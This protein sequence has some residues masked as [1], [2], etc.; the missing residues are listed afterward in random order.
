MVGAFKLSFPSCISSYFL[1]RGIL[2]M[3]G[4]SCRVRTAHHFAKQSFA[5]KCVPKQSMGTRGKRIILQKTE[6]RNPKTFTMPPPRITIVM[7]SFNQ[8]EY[9]EEAM[10]S[11]LDQG[12]VNL[13]FM[14]L[15]G[16]SRDNSSA[17]IEKYA[18]RLA[19]WQSRP[20]G[21]QSDALAQG[22]A[23][24]TGDLWGWINSDDALLPG[25][26]DAIG[27]AAQVCPAA[28]L[29]GGNYMLMDQAGR[30]TRCK[31]HPANAGWFAGRGIFAFNPPG[32][33]FRPRY[34][35]AVGG[36]RRDLHFA[37][38][39]DLYFR[40]IAQ[41]AMYVHVDRYLSVFRQH[42]AQKPTVHR[43]AAAAEMARLCR[44]EWPQPLS[45]YARQRRW[46]WLYRAWQTLNGNY[47]RMALDTLKLKGRRWQDV[48]LTPDA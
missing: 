20:D 47:L 27:R 45:R 1:K 6:N 39:N 22:F 37:M 16:G 43:Q 33:F 11:I 41:G 30:V 8:G 19:Y 13:E 35:Q 38:D 23:R 15:D 2:P 21:G 18:H 4:F 48:V 25:A 32:S 17:I 24:A 14:V 10:R 31:R 34:Y 46:R 12:Y 36:V 40:M 9:L 5:G 28:G 29:Y 42:A 44:E 26:L 3:M 7:P